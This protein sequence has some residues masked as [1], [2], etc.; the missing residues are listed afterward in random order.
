[1]IRN[2]LTPR[3]RLKSR[4][5]LSSNMTASINFVSLTITVQVSDDYGL[6]ARISILPSEWL[7]VKDPRSSDRSCILLI[8]KYSMFH[9]CQILFPYSR[10]T[11][12]QSCARVN[13]SRSDPTHTKLDPIRPVN[14][15]YFHSTE[16]TVIGRITL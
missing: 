16:R 4:A 8:F 12:S 7:P 13:F 11:A 9:G 3:D 6:L 5:V 15:R 1:M 14:K 10:L 2:R